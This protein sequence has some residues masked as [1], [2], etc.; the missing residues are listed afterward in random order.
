MVAINSDHLLNL[1]PTVGG[2]RVESFV[3]ELLDTSHNALGLLDVQ[4]STPSIALDT[5]RAIMR[6]CSGVQISSRT[7]SDIDVRKH[8]LRPSLV[9][10]NGARYS[11]GVFMFGNDVRER[12]SYGTKWMPD[13]FDESFIVGQALGQ[14]YSWAPGSS[15]L[16]AIAVLFGDVGFPTI[17]VG[18]AD[19][20][21]RTPLI[22]KAGTL[23]IDAANALAALLGAYPP[24]F[25]NNG[26]P[27]LRAAP[28]VGAQVN[29]IYDDGGHVVAGFT[30]LTN[31]WY[32]AP[33][34]YIVTG[35]DVAAG[36][37][38]VYDLPAIAENSFANMGV[39]VTQV[40]SMQGLASAAIANTAAYVQALIDTTSYLQGSF[41][42]TVDP[43][44]G[45]YDLVQLYGAR[46]QETGWTIS[47][48]LGA[49][50]THTLTGIY[51]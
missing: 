14:T 2:Q 27:T 25:D 49:P 44:H 36:I 7:F 16:G 18:V 46:Y 45:A 22:Y 34:R 23:R 26:V 24:Y 28:L 9:L 47:C 39:I 5:S 51:G 37:V 15:V 41:Q 20:A 43:R 1:D 42:S 32:K 3:F 29:H 33:N 31:S 40:T 35:D 50:M 30:Q 4:A 48:A 12:T 6:T 13:L 11:L 8:R 21:A 17:A 38:G 10:S 19:Q